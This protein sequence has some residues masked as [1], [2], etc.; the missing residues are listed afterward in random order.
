MPDPRKGAWKNQGAGQVAPT[1]GKPAQWKGQQTP[2]GN[3]FTPFWR[4]KSFK[5]AVDW[6][7]YQLKGDKTAAKTFVGPDC[8]LCT[9][10]LWEVKRKNM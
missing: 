1:P 9:N 10:P 2:S 8:K 7:K 4:R 6:F 3:P 5:I